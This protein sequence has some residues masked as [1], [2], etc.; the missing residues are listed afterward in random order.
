VFSIVFYSS[1]GSVFFVMGVKRFV[2]RNC[3]KRGNHVCEV[4]FVVVRGRRFKRFYAKCPHCF[5]EG[6]FRF[7]AGAG[8]GVRVV[9]G[10][11][12]QA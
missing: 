8:K 7:D 10:A 1:C 12:V 5:V 9:S 4:R 6:E 11:K 2:C 3:Y